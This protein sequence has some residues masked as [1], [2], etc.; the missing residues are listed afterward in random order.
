MEITDS[1]FIKWWNKLGEP[2]KKAIIFFYLVNNRKTTDMTSFIPSKEEIYSHLNKPLDKSLI[3]KYKSIKT[4]QFSSRNN[5]RQSFNFSTIKYIESLKHLTLLDTNSFRKPYSL[6]FLKNLETL[7]FVNCTRLYYISR[8]EHI[9]NLLHI[10]IS[11]CPYLNLSYLNSFVNIQYLFIEHSDSLYLSPETNLYN[12]R[13]LEIVNCKYIEIV[14]DFKKLP[15]LLYLK[16]TKTTGKIIIKNPQYARSI[17]RMEFNKSQIVNPEELNLIPSL[18][19]FEEKQQNN[20]VHC[21]ITHF[22]SNHKIKITLTKKGMLTSL[23]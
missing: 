22:P 2:A 12:L 13:K 1:A 8:S 18:Y 6:K 14:L 7:S 21:I 10:S 4:F 9:E 19:N 3:E 17:Q 5:N 15:S 23:T 16:I 11:Y 20:K